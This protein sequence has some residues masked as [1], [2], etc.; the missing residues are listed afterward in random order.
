MHYQG[1]EAVELFG[2]NE[3][4]RLTL[5]HSERTKLPGLLLMSVF[6][7][8][9]VLPQIG[10]A[11][12]ALASPEFRVA[13]A[14]QPIVAIELATAFAFWTGLVCWPLRKIFL[15]L[16]SDRLVDIRDGEVTVIDKSFF[17]SSTWRLPLGT[18]DG[19]AINVRTSLSGSR[20]E[21]MLVHPEA[22][23][24]VVLATADHFGVP[25]VL[26]LCRILRL[27]LLPPDRSYGS[28]ENSYTPKDD[29]TLAPAT[30]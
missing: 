29:G 12:Y 9:I 19:V 13:L 21:V 18:Y 8:A 11:I 30:T 20:Q 10:L 25:E 23:R 7:G 26:A 3:Q 2:G 14:D 28:G 5:R 1:F 6:A 17:S 27:P 24:S 22:E 4:W 16:T 15:A